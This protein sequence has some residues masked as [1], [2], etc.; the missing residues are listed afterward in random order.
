MPMGVTI[1][2]LFSAPR[3]PPLTSLEPH[4]TLL[5]DVSRGGSVHA[6]NFW[7]EV[8]LRGDPR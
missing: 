1:V 6:E 3:K 8:P 5:L 4:A 2:G 7:V